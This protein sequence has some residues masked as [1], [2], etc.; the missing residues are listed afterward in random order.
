M[1]ILRPKTLRSLPLGLMIEVRAKDVAVWQVFLMKDCPRV[2]EEVFL[3]LRSMR[4]LFA[5]VL[6]CGWG[7]PLACLVISGIDVGNFDA[8]LEVLLLV[9]PRFLIPFVPHDDGLLTESVVA[10]N[11]SF[12]I[13]R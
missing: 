1:K 13:L 7:L 4:R 8:D 6:L 2:F 9:R 12:D 11:R 3:K 5:C 10:L